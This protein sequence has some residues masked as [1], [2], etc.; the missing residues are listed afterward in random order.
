[1]PALLLSTRV[2]LQRSSMLSGDLKS[3]VTPVNPAGS[4]GLLQPAGLCALGVPEPGLPH[5][6]RQPVRDRRRVAVQNSVPRQ[7]P[8]GGRPP[9]G[10]RRPARY[11]VVPC[12]RVSNFLHDAW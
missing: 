10:A 7:P 6:A 1:M 5:R 2:I 11:H 3:Q 9:A 12:A 8:A 4:A